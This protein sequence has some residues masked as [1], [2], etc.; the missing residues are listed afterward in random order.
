MD[1]DDAVILTLALWAI[2]C[3]VL[4]NAVDVYVTLLLIAI[5]VVAEIAGSFIKPQTKQGL[6]PAIYFL[7]FVFC[8]I[9]AKKVM[10]VLS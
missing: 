3:S 9:V 2:I 5:L 8:I 6:R 7:L 4:V 10:E 1:V